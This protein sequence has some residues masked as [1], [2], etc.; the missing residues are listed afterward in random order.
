MQ[1]QLYIPSV[2]LVLYISIVATQKQPKPNNAISATDRYASCCIFTKARKSNAKPNYNAGND[3]CTVPY[4]RRRIIYNRIFFFV[5][6]QQP[7]SDNTQHSRQTSM[8]PAGFEPTIPTGERPQ[9][10]ALDQAVKGTGIIG[11]HNYSY[12][13]V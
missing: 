2:S 6:A 10:Y 8:P 4:H 1:L 9:T 11:F 5:L 13:Q 12:M 3:S 7:L